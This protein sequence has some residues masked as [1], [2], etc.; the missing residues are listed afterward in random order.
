MDSHSGRLH[1]WTI[2]GVNFDEVFR[3]GIRGAAQ[4]L[5]GNGEP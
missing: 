2:S 1:T 3:V 4:I 5:S